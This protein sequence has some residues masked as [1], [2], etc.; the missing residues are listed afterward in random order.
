MN[1]AA[2]RAVVANVN[3]LETDEVK[4]RLRCAEAPA[5]N[6]TK[7]IDAGLTV[8][9]RDVENICAGLS[10]RNGEGRRSRGVSVPKSKAAKLSMLI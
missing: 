1:G 6:V 10:I 7:R 3:G 5:M 8:G 2:A 4:P 9:L